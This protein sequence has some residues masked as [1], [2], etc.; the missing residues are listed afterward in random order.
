VS[1]SDFGTFFLFAEVSDEPLVAE[2]KVLWNNLPVSVSRL[3]WDG[4]VGVGGWMLR[5]ECPVVESPVLSDGV[6][7]S[8][9]VRMLRDELPAVERRALSDGV[10]GVGGQ[11]PCC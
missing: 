1:F 4:V 3:L 9:G 7:V 11:M 8:A 6:S 5:D 2:G 10:A